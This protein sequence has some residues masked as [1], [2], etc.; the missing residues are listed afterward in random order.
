MEWMK[1]NLQTGLNGGEMPNKNEY[2]GIK[3]AMEEFPKMKLSYLNLKYNEQVYEQ[4]KSQMVGS[5]NAFDYISK[6]LGYRLFISKVQY[7]VSLKKGILWNRQCVEIVL[8]NSGFAPIGKSYELEW[9]VE[10]ADGN[11]HCFKEKQSLAEVETG[12]WV[13][14]SLKAKLL[15]KVNARRIGIRIYKRDDKEKCS[16]GCVEL[17]NDELLYQEGVNWILFVDENGEV[18]QN[19]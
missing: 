13:S 18:M 8:Q 16:E 4:W 2:S 10:D 5:E 6:H 9:V 15:K 7:P 1:E 14:V 11:I 12:E 17:V 19:Q 3:R